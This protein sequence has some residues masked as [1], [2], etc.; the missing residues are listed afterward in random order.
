MK[1]LSNFFRDKRWDKIEKQDNGSIQLKNTTAKKT[2][3]V[4][5]GYIEGGIIGGVTQ[6][7]RLIYVNANTELEANRVASILVS[8]NSS[9]AVISIDEMQ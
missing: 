2:Y 3:K 1:W 7:K 9:G 8:W 4:Q 5:I 6:E